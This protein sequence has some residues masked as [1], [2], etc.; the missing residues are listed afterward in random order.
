V[1]WFLIGGGAIAVALAAGAAVVDRRARRRGH[2]IRS[3]VS[4]WGDVRESRR[5]ARA[6]ESQLGTVPPDVSWTAYARKDRRG[7][8][9]EV[10]EDESVAD[11]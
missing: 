1:Q 11:L 9:S 6:Y 3:G 2:R 7:G 5:D 10:G 8:T 4:M